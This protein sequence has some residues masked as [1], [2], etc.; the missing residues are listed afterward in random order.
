MASNS[1]E[2][3]KKGISIGVEDFKKIIE[4]NEYFGD[5]IFFA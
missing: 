4:K 5:K 3:R 2:E 1:I